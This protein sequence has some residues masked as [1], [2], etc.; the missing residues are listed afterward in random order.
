MVVLGQVAERPIW[1]ISEEKPYRQPK[2]ANEYDHSRDEQERHAVIPIDD[3]M[4]L[5][6]IGRLIIKRKMT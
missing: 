1:S 3:I 4:S 5:I 6:G 2:E